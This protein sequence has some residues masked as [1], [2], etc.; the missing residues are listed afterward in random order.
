MTASQ[1]RRLAE[2]AELLDA[3]LAGDGDWEV[4]GVAHP[5]AA[6]AGD[7]A[8]AMEPE[9]LAALPGSR[10][11]AAVVARDAEVPAADLAGVLAVD[12]PRVA[13]ARLLDLFDR[14]LHVGAG[15]HPSAVID[16][17]AQLADGVS[18]GPLCSIGPSVSIGSGTA[19]AAQVTVGAGATLGADCLVHAGVRIGDRVE[20]GSR[21]IIQPN[22]VI[23][24]DG[25]SFVTPQEGSAEAA[26]RGRSVAGRNVTILRINSVGTVR[27]GDDVEIGAGTTIDRA[28]LDA[29][30]I[31]SGTKIDNL[32]QIAHNCRIGENCMIAGNCGL[33]GSV[34]LG[35]RVVLAGS[36]GIA[37]HLRIGDDAVIAARSGVGR[38][39]PPAAVFGG[40]PA[41][42]MEEK[43]QELLHLGRLKRM[44]K[45]LLD[46][47][48]RVSALEKRGA[49]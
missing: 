26:K 28:T 18:I 14:P 3:G 23:G 19:L 37:D 38:H 27:I 25:F 45:D 34:V 39:V 29:T 9:S 30:T 32:C 6:V 36:V 13:L 40:Y 22:A 1:S 47:Q 46:V 11:R 8:L 10:A 31:G 15:I 4:G 24:A 33:S 48:R 42:P 5:A 35:D 44:F 20:I 49:K 21:V 12:R 17:T 7:L 41:M 2:L 16:P 43:K